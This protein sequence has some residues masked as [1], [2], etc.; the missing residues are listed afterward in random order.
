MGFAMWQS[1]APKSSSPGTQEPL[2]TLSQSCGIRLVDGYLG[3]KSNELI[4][5]GFLGL[6][7]YRGESPY[8]LLWLLS[9]SVS[10]QTFQLSH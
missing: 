3:F 1:P 5:L 10:R 2:L 8:P 9:P 4:L 6:Q 7:E